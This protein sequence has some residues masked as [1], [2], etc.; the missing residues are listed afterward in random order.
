MSS[1]RKEGAVCGETV[2]N[3]KSKDGKFECHLFSKTQ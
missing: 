3:R 1:G 2:W